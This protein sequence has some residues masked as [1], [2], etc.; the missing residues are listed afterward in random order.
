M[1][2]LPRAELLDELRN[3][4]GTPAE[5]LENQE[6]MELIIPTLRAD[7]AVVEEYRYYETPVLPVPI[8]VFA[9]E[10][11]KYDSIEQIYGWKEETSTAFRVQWFDGDHFFINSHRH[12]VLAAINADLH[13]HLVIPTKLK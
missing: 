11:D 9:G 8:T 5:V 1:H 2:N 3:Y 13:C 4:N 7:F 12:E 6:L 10:R